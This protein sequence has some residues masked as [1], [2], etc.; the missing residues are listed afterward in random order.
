KNE[1]E[2]VRY[3]QNALPIAEKMNDLKYMA[4]LSNNIG[5]AYLTFSQ[6][7]QKAI[8]YFERCVELSDKIGYVA[9]SQNAGFNLAQI[10]QETGELDKALTEI[11][12]VVEQHGYNRFA[13][14]VIGTI[15][16]KKGEYQQAI[17]TFK[18]LLTTPL[19]SREQELEIN[20]SI[21]EAYKMSGNL[22]STV[23]YLE[24]TY[25]LRDSL[26]KHQ[27]VQTIHDLKIAYETEKK[28]TQ[29]T[30]LEEEKRLMI[31]L[32]VAV[33][34]ILL[35]ALTVF[36]FLW[37]WT[38][39][40]RRIA[41]QQIK[42]LEQEK[43]LVATQ[44][45]LDGETQERIRLARDLHDRLGGILS[46]LK[47]SM[48]NMRNNIT[49]DVASEEIYNKSMELLEESMREMR[50]VAHHLMPET[51]S[52]SGLQTA[53][54]EFCKS[55]PHAKFI[56]HG[57]DERLETKLELLVYRIAYELVNNAMKHS[58]ASVILTQIVCE[59][60][61]ISL[62]VQDNGC[63][64]DT[65]TTAEGMGLSN[66]RTYM[67]SYNGLID[68]CSTIGEGTEIYVEFQIKPENCSIY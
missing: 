34:A 59:P 44:A 32:G 41:G 24:K 46:T 66:I 21:S 57:Y 37:R 64:F 6:D 49:Q 16:F 22:D 51:L 14:I 40:K 52:R 2:A 28:E 39:Q 42:Q 19:I 30:R 26:H 35:L 13:G 31:W 60:D 27:S 17:Q 7:F 9:G 20:K 18:G 15:Y 43:Q 25:A 3:Y 47:Y 10:Y 65:R 45:L 33:C 29:I 23:V 1:D 5:N 54:S 56:W 55:I 38:V 63:G 4:I 11:N 50:R 53:L 8:P 36:F 12:R 62:T 68:I 67:T 48:A 61:R 58:G